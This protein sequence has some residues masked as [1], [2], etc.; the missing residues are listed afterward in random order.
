MDQVRVRLAYSDYPVKLTLREIITWR[1]EEMLGGGLLAGIA[2]CSH[3]V[4]PRS[5]EIDALYRL[6]HVPSA[7]KLYISFPISRVPSKSMGDQIAE[8]RNEFQAL[9][10]CVVFDPIKVTEEPRLLASL[11][12]TLSR[13]PDEATVKVETLGQ[14]VHLD[15]Q[16]LQ[17]IKADIRN[18]T[19]SFDYRMIDQSEAIVAFV[20]QHKGQP[21]V[22]EGVFM[23]I[24]HAEYRGNEIYLIWPSDQSPSPMINAD[25]TFRSVKEAVEFFEK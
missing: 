19:R 24:A 18:L 11:K 23:E 7:K 5:F 1:E 22:A 3:Y 14:E 20:P 4:V 25:A 13:E 15:V 9:P 2:G 10:N 6:I 8:F 16:E 17:G 12:K 21:Y